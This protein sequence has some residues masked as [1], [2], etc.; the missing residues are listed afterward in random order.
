MGK[1]EKGKAGYL[2][3]KKRNNLIYTII[4][5]AVVVA[6]F[7]AGLLIFKSRNN[8]MTLVSVVLVLPA[9]KIAVGYFILLPHHSC[10]GDLVKRLN[11]EAPQLV[12]K[13]DLIISNT[14]KPVGVQACIITEKCICVLTD[15]MKTDQKFFEKSVFDFLKNEKLNVS[16]SMY[17]DEDTFLKRVQNLSR[18]FDAENKEH[19]D[20][21][22]WNAEGL[23]HMCI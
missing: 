18:N 19:T 10:S 17:T 15:E 4:A 21:M 23:M 3:E 20:R 2:S 22:S 13:Y 11:Q 5:F 12:K 6:V 8:Y 7:V 14:K 1:I 9:A 16:V